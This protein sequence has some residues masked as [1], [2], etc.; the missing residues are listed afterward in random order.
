M[1]VQITEYKKQNGNYLN[2]PMPYVAKNNHK[3]TIY[4]LIIFDWTEKQGKH[5]QS[6][7]D[8]VRSYD[9]NS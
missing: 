6:T 2:I 1:V 7:S 4:R 3:K 9:H 8:I 5:N